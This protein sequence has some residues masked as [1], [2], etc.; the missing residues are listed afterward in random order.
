MALV[1]VGMA[2]AHSG[3]LGLAW[4][5]HSVGTAL[6]QRWHSV[7]TALAWVGMGRHGVGTRWHDPDDRTASSAQVHYAVI[8]R[9]P[10]RDATALIVYQVLSEADNIKLIGDYMENHMS[11]DPL[12]T[13]HLPNMVAL[14]RI[15]GMGGDARL[16]ADSHGEPSIVEGV[17][18]TYCPV[19]VSEY[20]DAVME[21]AAKKLDEQTASRRVGATSADPHL[22]MTLNTFLTKHSQ[23]LGSTPGDG[24]CIFY[25]IDATLGRI[26]PPVGEMADE[27]AYLTAR[28]ARTLLVHI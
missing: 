10:P 6:A 19:G 17:C 18:V 2:S 1:H 7:G 11:R 8:G 25:A 5:W 12:A 13:R 24:N 16:G 14:G 26:P 23:E 27:V 20:T 21:A 4:G 15:P 3:T 9:A 22:G 28:E